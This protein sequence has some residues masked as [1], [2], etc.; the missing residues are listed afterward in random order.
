LN[1]FISEAQ[2][3]SPEKKNIR[4]GLKIRFSRLTGKPFSDYLPLSR[5]P[6]P[7]LPPTGSFGGRGERVIA[8]NQRHFSMANPLGKAPARKTKAKGGVLRNPT[9]SEHQSP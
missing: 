5:N 2:F 4:H 9:P 7:P 3:L 1:N 6:Y 8:A